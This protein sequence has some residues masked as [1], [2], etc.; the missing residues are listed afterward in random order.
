M[1]RRKVKLVWVANKTSRMLSLKKRRIGVLKKAK[2]LAILCDTTTCMIMFSPN[3]A[4]PTVF[5]SV[6]AV[7][8][9]LDDFF[10][11][12]LVE[13]K[14]KDTNIVSYLAEKTDKAHEQLMKIHEKNME[15]ETDQLM[16]Q[17]QH[18]RKFDDLNLDEIHKLLSFSKEKIMHLRKKLDSMEH[19]P[20]RDHPVNP[21]EARPEE[22]RTT[23]NDVSVGGGQEDDRSER[24]DETAGKRISIGDVIRENQPHYIMDKWFFPSPEPVNPQI[25]QTI[26]M[27]TASYIANPNPR[28]YLPYQGSSSSSGNPHF[29]GMEPIGTPAMT[30]HGSVGPV[31]QPLQH[32]NMSQPRQYRTEEGININHWRSNTMTTNDGLHQM[33]PPPNVDAMSFAFNRDWPGF[34]NGSYR[35][36]QGSSSNGNPRFEHMDPIGT[37]MMTFPGLVGSVSQPLQQ[38]NVINNPMMSMSQPRQYRLEEGS[39]INNNGVPQFHWR[40]NAMTTNDG[41][42]QVPQPPHGT[43]AAEGNVD[44]MLFGINMDWPGFNNPHF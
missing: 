44:S 23:T 7:R 43:T 19:R 13:Q 27:E 35:P 32:H 5:P 14:R 3:E 39:N 40:S 20:L 37:P 33:P 6:D 30:F 4:E 8:D 25:H 26:R 11:L 15:Q 17:L 18:G 38:H 42:R 24:I 16:V 28:S 36:Y 29:Q 31:S 1:G 34:N 10:A 22:F 2:E 12:P 41:L 21:F 9:I